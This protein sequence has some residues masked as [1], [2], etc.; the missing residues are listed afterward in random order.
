MGKTLKIETIVF[1]EVLSVDHLDPSISDYVCGF[2]VS[3]NIRI[4]PLKQNK[5]KANAFVPYRLNGELQTPPYEE[6]QFCLFLIGG[7]WKQTPFCGDEWWGE[8]FRLGYSRT[9]T[10]GSKW[11]TDGEVALMLHP[12]EEVPPGFIQ[13]RI[14]TGWSKAGLQSPI[15][16]KLRA[17]DPKT[18]EDGF[19]NEIPANFI[20]GV[21]P[22]KRKPKGLP[23]SADPR[24]RI[25]IIS[26]KE[27]IIQ[28]YLSGDS[29]ATLG[30]R[31]NTYSS[32]INKWITMWGVPK[33]SRGRRSV[34]T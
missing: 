21:P 2:D 13:G 24:A 18:G 29:M 5:K 12:D 31:Y 7:E 14:Y 16:N 28:S 15:K 11:Y 27:E 23:P 33:R 1:M 22:E 19:F 26:K 6:G 20:A 17:H 34:K 10:R 9:N 3:N 25:D 8:V 4:I 30:K 32:A